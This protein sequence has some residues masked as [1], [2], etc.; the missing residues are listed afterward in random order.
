VIRPGPPSTRAYCAIDIADSVSSAKEDIVSSAERF[1]RHHKQQTDRT[2]SHTYKRLAGDVRASMT[3][4]ELLGRVRQSAPSVLAAPVVDGHHLGVEALA[5]LSLRRDVWV[6]RL[7]SWRG[8]SAS[9]Q[10]AV[11]SLADHLV[12]RYP[13]PRFLAAAWYAT[14]ALAEA[15]RE[16][17]VAHARGTRVRSLDLPIAMTRRM[18]HIFLAS[19]DHLSID[20]ALRRAELIALG[21]SDEIVR[22]VC[23]TPLSSDLRHGDFWRTVWLFLI[24]NAAAIEPSQIEPLIDFVQAIR[25]E[26]VA[27][28]TAQG[29]IVHDPPQPAFSMRGRTAPSMLRLMNDWHHSLAHAHGGL[30]WHPAPVQPML[31]EEPSLDP[32]APPK[33]WQLTELTNGEQLR[34]E[35]AALRH[36]VASYA[37]RCWE[38]GSRIWSLRVLRGQRVRRVLTIEVDLRRRMIV[39][40]RGWRN[41]RAGG[42]PLRLLQEWSARER[43][44]MAI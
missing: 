33:V 1:V 35:G 44:R 27:V 13:V 43:L 40:A 5:N 10:A 39:Q 20:L 12:C 18:E 3:F 19:P 42:K 16:W 8:S 26:R 38:G 21:A 37:H 2:I 9:W 24:A 34:E 30:T 6:R 14:G 17:F 23:K 25:H 41:R 32:S 29:I 11:C 7:A 36:C 22:A 15:K 4:R 31:V 28:E